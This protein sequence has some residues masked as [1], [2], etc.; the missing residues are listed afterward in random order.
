MYETRS[1]EHDGRNLV[2]DD[3]GSGDS[4]VVYM[5]ALLLNSDI[6]RGIAEALAEQGHRVI[7]LD[8]LGHGRSDSPTHASEYRIDSYAR[9]VFSLMDHL[10]VQ[11]AVLAGIS[12]GA[13]TSLFAAASRPERVRGLVLEMPVLEWAVPAAAMTFVPMLLAAR[14]G[15]PVVRAFGDLVRRVPRTGLGL[16]DALLSI[17]SMPPEV[18]ASILHGVL[19]GPVAPTQEERAAIDAPALLLAH[20][21]DFIHPFSDAENLQRQLPNATLE[22]AHSPA[23]LRLHPE[24]LTECISDFL[25]GLE[26]P[27]ATRGTPAAKPTSARH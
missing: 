18:M 17:G 10:G 2:Y 24:R 23:E 16:V 20:G 13:N 12:L 4:V 27:G 7:L 11:S 26:A 14:Y 15:R 25:D 19:V 9:Q 5:H 8:L 21:N 3:Y 1:F 6:N 22:R